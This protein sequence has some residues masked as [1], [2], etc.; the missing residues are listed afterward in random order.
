MLIC[1]SNQ[2]LHIN[3]CLFRML[4]NVCLKFIMKSPKTYTGSVHFYCNMG[5]FSKR[6][7]YLDN[8]VFYKSPLIWFFAI[9]L[10]LFKGILGISELNQLFLCMINSYVS[11]N[12]QTP[13][14]VALIIHFYGHWF[15]CHFL[16]PGTTMLN[17]VNANPH[18][19]QLSGFTMVIKRVSG[20]INVC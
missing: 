9:C 5:D 4:T 7:R 1:E 2:A 20:V 18:L 17:V 8:F 14:I 13:H 3:N 10:C 16:K 12:V 11:K 15:L 6:I 19:A